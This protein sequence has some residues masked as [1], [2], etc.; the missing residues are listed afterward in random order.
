MKKHHLTARIPYGMYGLLKDKAEARGISLTDAVIEALK[1][2][3]AIA[4]IRRAGLGEVL[5]AQEQLAEM[6]LAA[7]TDTEDAA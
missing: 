7:L 3:L 1:D 2:G 4:A 5:K 6:R